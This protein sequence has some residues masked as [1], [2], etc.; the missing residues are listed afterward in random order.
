MSK[1]LIE[2]VEEDKVNQKVST[3]WK[4]LISIEV[5]FS[6]FFTNTCKINLSPFVFFENISTNVKLVTP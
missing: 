6:S 3:K 2:G 1:M 5:R 4:I